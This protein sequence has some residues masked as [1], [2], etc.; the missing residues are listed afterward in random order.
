MGAISWREY[1]Y[2]LKRYF[3]FTKAELRDFLLVVLFFGL[4]FSFDK[5]GGAEFNLIEGLKNL[6]IAFVLVAVSV[7]IHHAVQRLAAIYLGYRPDQRIWWL[8]I[9]IGLAVL[10]FSNG[11]IMIFA[12]TYLMIHMLTKERLGKYRYG[13]SV[14][15]FGYAAMLGPV[16]NLLFAGILKAI[17]MSVGSSTLDAFV[18]LNLLLALYNTLPV[19]PLDG[20]RLLFG[21]RLGYFFFI[22]GM[23]GFL[24]LFYVLALSI[25]LCLVLSFVVGVVFWLVFYIAFERFL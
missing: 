7:F 18:G 20:S 4:I 13:P 3:W 23:L 12:G 2:R 10:I 6:L 19:P 5:W 11:R 24:V 15:S 17:N 16:A 9:F 25:L 14:K 22:G 21:S 8:G 1:K